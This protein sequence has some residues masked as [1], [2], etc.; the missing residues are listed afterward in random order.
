MKSYNL[1]EIK[2]S[3][4]TQLIEA[5]S[6]LDSSETD[7]LFVFNK[8]QPIGYVPDSAIRQYLIKK[9]SFNTQIGN[10]A[11]KDFYKIQDIDAN[12]IKNYFITNAHAEFLPILNGSEV[13]IFYRSDFF[14]LQVKENLKDVP[15]VIMAGGEGRRLRPYTEILPKPLLPLDGSTIIERI[16]S[17]FRAYKI[18]NFVITINYKADL[19][20]SYFQALKPHYNVSFIQEPKPLGTAGSLSYLKN[21]STKPFFVSNCDILIN[22]DYQK[23]YN[24]HVSK[25][26]DIS[27]IAAVMPYQVPYG[28]CEVDENFSLLEIQEKP[29]F[30]YLVNSGL[31]IINPNLIDIIPENQAFDMT[32]FINLV[33]KLDGKVGVYP[34]SAQSWQDFGQ[35]DLYEKTLTKKLKNSTENEV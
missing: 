22:T 1:N 31:Y 27:L 20:K 17:K 33:H 15:V 21:F 30:Y 14:P 4:D 7:L 29:T 3:A 6:F 35:L 26:F 5:L 19:I 16:I 9:Q 13:K 32:Q 12:F 2:I 24:F 28:I 8:K 34:I 11:V 23:I 10:L 25:K 18:N